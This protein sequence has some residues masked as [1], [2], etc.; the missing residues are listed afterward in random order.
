MS[1]ELPIQN[2]FCFFF[3]GLGADLKF[4]P[5]L[6]LGCFFPTADGIPLKGEFVFSNDSSAV[7]V[8][9]VGHHIHVRSPHLKLSL[10]VNDGRKGGTDQEGTFGVALL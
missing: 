9:D 3:I 6:H 10:P 8:P 4:S 5:Y 1:D 7:F 2:N